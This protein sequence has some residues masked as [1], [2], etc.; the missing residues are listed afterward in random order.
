VSGARTSTATVAGAGVRPST[1][2][3]LSGQILCIAEPDA[4]LTWTNTVFD[5]ALGY[6]AGELVGKSLLGLAHPDDRALADA[7]GGLPPDGGEVAGVRVRMRSARGSWRWLEWTVRVDAGRGRL[8]G[9]ARDVTDRLVAEASLRES[10]ARL[11]AILEHSPSAIF[12]EDLE[13]RY[14]LV[15]SEWSRLTGVSPGEAVGRNASEM[16][17]DTAQAITVDDRHVLAEQGALV[18]D[19][20]RRTADGV[21]DYMFVRFLLRDAEGTPTGIAGI[22]TDITERKVAERALAERES[23]LDTVL[24][25]S[26]DII[27]IMDRHG[28]IRQES[29]A[30]RTMLGY[31][32]AAPEADMFA[33]V[34][35][36][37]FPAVAQTFVDLVEGNTEH[38]QMRYRVRHA[39]G[40]WLV[41]DSRGR[42]LLDEHN[43]FDGAALV[44]RDVTA[45]L[46]SDTK[47]QAAREAAENASSAK[48]EFLSR[49]SHELRT[50]LNAVLGFAQLLQMDGLPVEQADA[51]D[52][53]LRA[54][55]HLLDLIDEV[56][57]IAR[58]ESGHL[59]LAMA[60]VDVEEIVA[61]AV[62]LVRPLA[63]RAEVAVH[64]ASA[65]HAGPAVRADRQRLVQVLLNLLSNAV[66]YNRPGGRVD[67]TWE[68]VDARR[69]RLVVADTGRGIRSEDLDRVF[70]P[71]DRIGAEQ[72][73]VEGTGVGLAVSRHLV[74]RMG[75]AIRVESVPDV[76]STFSVELLLADDAP[77]GEHRA[78]DA[79]PPAPAPGDGDGR[80]RVLLIEAELTSLELVERVV[81]RRSGVEVLAAMHGGLGVD[82]AREHVPDLVLL[83]LD[84]PDMAAASVLE[85]L[86]ADDTT[87][88]IPV[89]VLSADASPVEVRELLRRGVA[90]HLARPLDV[91]ALLSLVDAVAAA[92]G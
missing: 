65:S 77:A 58:I 54:G 16:W 9:A 5:R 19:E 12:V 20:R 66:K 32:D 15:N 73:G 26:P 52:H 14:Q 83:D 45:K 67:V 46:E 41:F 10:E 7:V 27:S 48:S 36:D 18:T 49:M 43:R 50:P 55:R 44:S 34:H 22:A 79:P 24:Q 56:L 88:R 21:R 31:G 90:G 89:A 39:D 87:A 80:L 72:T 25:A 37:D 47:L 40:R 62:M 6:R 28:R 92:R 75:G 84:L 17:P 81:S 76:G 63:E 53:I 78:A 4:T 74:E 60:P 42:A 61:D 3:E 13:G 1:F 30:Q 11:R 64:L 35:P 57:D 69:A 51:V 91:R 33:L 29:R 68:R 23:V 59:E 86:A 82:L 2:V 38:V 85:R 70:V 71:F 8:Y